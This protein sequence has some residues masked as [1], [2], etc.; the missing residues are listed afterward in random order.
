MI[1]LERDGVTLGSKS[2]T[3]E[4]SEVCVYE[5]GRET[6]KKNP[7]EGFLRLATSSVNEVSMVSLFK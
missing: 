2:V 3:L 6:V 4:I 7:M 1:W 5:G